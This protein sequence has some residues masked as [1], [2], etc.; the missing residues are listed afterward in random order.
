M[1]TRRSRVIVG[2]HSAINTF[3]L[4]LVELQKENPSAK[5]VWIMRK[6]FVEEVYGGEEKDALKVCG[7]LGI[8]IHELVDAGKIEV[9][10]QF[11]MATGF[12]QVL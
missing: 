8:R 11:Y 10:T 3:L 7:A 2:G 1:T 6:N 4:S 12:E 5:L 9:L